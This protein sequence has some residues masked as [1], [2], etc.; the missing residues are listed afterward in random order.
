MSI[1]VNVYD[2]FAAN[3]GSHAWAVQNL[4]KSKENRPKLVDMNQPPCP[5]N[6]PGI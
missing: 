4:Y 1:I 3:I 6:V 5:L 2:I